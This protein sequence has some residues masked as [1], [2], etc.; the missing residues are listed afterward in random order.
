MQASA[1]SLLPPVGD[2]LIGYAVCIGAA[3]LVGRLHPLARPRRGPAGNWR[4]Q[5]PCP[6][7][8]TAA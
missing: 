8:P 7:R 5:P 4:G 2:V 6:G 3:V 1:P